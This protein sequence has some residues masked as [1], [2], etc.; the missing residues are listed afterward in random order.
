MRF[1]GTFFGLL[2][3]F[4]MPLSLLAFFVF[5]ISLLWDLGALLFY[6]QVPNSGFAIPICSLLIFLVL[7]KVSRGGLMIADKYLPHKRRHSSL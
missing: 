3:I 6:T 2:A 5:A 1:L 7:S 4:V